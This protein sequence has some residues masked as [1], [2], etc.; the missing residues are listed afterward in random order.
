LGRALATVQGKTILKHL[1]K[2]EKSKIKKRD[3]I[4]SIATKLKNY[5]ESIKPKIKIRMGLHI[6]GYVNHVPKLRHVFHESWNAAGEFENE[7]C[8]KEYHIIPY[9]HTVKYKEHI[10][11]PILFNGDNLVANALFNYAPLFPPYYTINPHNLHLSDC[12]ELAARAKRIIEWA[13]A[14]GLHIRRFSIQLM[15]MLIFQ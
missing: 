15:M 9:G 10:E 8:H 11:Y 7:D 6:A 14:R 3:T 1:E 12:V 13:E 2:L 4:S 5:F